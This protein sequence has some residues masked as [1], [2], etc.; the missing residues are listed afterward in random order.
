MKGFFKF[1]SQSAFRVKGAFWEKSLAVFWVL[2]I[3]H[4]A[5]SITDLSSHCKKNAKLSSRQQLSF[6]WVV[7]FREL[8]GQ[9][10]AKSKKRQ[11]WKLCKSSHFLKRSQNAWFW[12]YVWKI[13]EI[14]VLEIEFMMIYNIFY[15][16]IH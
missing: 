8:P 16:Q 14:P 15:H 4:C 3:S 13:L 11:D 9:K 7:D 6:Y 10:T 12:H 1:L 5:I 2:D